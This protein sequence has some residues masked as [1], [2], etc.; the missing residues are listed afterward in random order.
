MTEIHKMQY[1][2]NSASLEEIFAVKSPIVVS[3]MET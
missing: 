3:E 2:F 1:S